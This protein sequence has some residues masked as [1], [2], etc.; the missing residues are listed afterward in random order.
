MIC[1]ILWFLV[2]RLGG[3]LPFFQTLIRLLEVTFTLELCT[4]FHIWLWTNANIFV[5]EGVKM[6]FFH[7]QSSAKFAV[8]YSQVSVPKCAKSSWCILLMFTLSRHG[9][10]RDHPGKAGAGAAQ[11]SVWKTFSYRPHK[12]PWELFCIFLSQKPAVGCGSR[13]FFH[14]YLLWGYSKWCRKCHSSVSSQCSHIAFAC[15]S[16]VAWRSSLA[17]QQNSPTLWSSTL[18]YWRSP[19]KFLPALL[20]LLTSLRFVNWY[21]I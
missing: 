1:F 3:L 10:L 4:Q 12:D 13:Y 18:V 21:E 7:M 11:Q 17:S 8:Q 14:Q 2:K 15:S 20:S 5:F 19:K 6:S 16:T 9:S